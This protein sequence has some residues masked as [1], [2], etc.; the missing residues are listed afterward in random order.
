M[1]T[2]RIRGDAQVRAMAKAE[3]PHALIKYFA[4]QWAT[5]EKQAQGALEH[6][7][8]AHPVGRWMR[9][10]KGI[11]PVIAAGLLAHIDIKKAPTA[12]AIW[13]FGGMDPSVI[14]N[15]AEYVR[16][17][18]T[19]TRKQT[20]SDWL[21]LISLCEDFNRKPLEVLKSSGHL[22]ATPDTQDALD[23]CNSMMGLKA[24]P[25]SIIYP[26]NVMR[27][28][29]PKE[30]LHEGYEEL[31]G[32]LKF[33]WK[34]LTILLT[35]R[36]WNASLK[37]LLWKVG[38]S[39]VKVSDAKHDGENAGYYGKWYLER[40]A[41]EVRLNDEGKLAHRAAEQLQ[42][43][44][45]RA[46]TI[47]KRAYESGKLPDAHV[48]RRAC[49][50]VVKLFVAHLHEV[51]HVHEYG[52]RPP[53]PYPIAH[54]EHVHYIPPP[55]GDEPLPPPAQPNGNGAKRRGRPKKNGAS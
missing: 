35:K 13:R 2:Q 6:Y 7:T 52:R 50:W 3:E 14:W 5:L 10:Q 51:M 47:A 16:G 17:H 18:V 39:F 21:A 27:E 48:H 54:L 45:F 4:E 24:K 22:E 1:Q 30:R 37:V 11:G 8:E 23:V 36:P 38:E 28:L 49:R 55:S 53:N 20:D 43:K 34:A 29:L 46:D 15:S 19:A 40:K 12:G 31:I 33:D 44:K 25:K 42:R 26:D 41:R 9:A 32:E